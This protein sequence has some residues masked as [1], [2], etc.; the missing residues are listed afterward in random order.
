VLLLWCFSATSAFA[1]ATLATSD[2]LPQSQQPEAPSPI[3]N[4]LNQPMIKHKS[5][6]KTLP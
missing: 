3:E 6:E 2:H 4:R 5:G 1:A